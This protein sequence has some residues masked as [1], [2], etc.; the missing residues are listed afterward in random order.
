MAAAVRSRTPPQGLQ[1]IRVDLEIEGMRIRGPIGNVGLEGVV[2]GHAGTTRAKHR[3]ETWIHHLL[4]TWIRGRKQVSWIFGKSKKKNKR[5]GERLGHITEPQ[6]HLEALVSLYKQGMREPLAFMPSTSETFFLHA[7][8]PN[9]AWSKARKS[10]LGTSFSA[11]TAE[12][13]DPSVRLV[14]GND[15]PF[16]GT[17]P[18]RSSSSTNLAFDALAIQVF[19]PLHAVLQEVEL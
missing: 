19:S 3:I 7:D 13:T 16:D 15:F 17:E 6:A 11:A 12:G 4:L 8:K 18:Y 1:T 9:E 10:W 2:F 14:F 5:L